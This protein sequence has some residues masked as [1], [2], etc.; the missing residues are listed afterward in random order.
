MRKEKSNYAYFLPIHDAQEQEKLVYNEKS[1]N[2]IY[3]WLGTQ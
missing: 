3:Y 2:N 1:Q